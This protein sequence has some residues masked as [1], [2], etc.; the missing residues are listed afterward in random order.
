MIGVWIGVKMS[1]K[2]YPSVYSDMIKLLRQEE[3]MVVRL[4]AANTV[5]TVVDDLDFH[6]KSFLEFLEPMF[7]SLFTLLQQAQECDTKVAV[8][9]YYS[10]LQQIEE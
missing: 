6:Q 8:R 9:Y 4:T 2:L 5:R 7:Q 3:D 10:R 1:S